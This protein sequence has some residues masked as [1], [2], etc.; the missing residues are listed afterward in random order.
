M[1]WVAKTLQIK[2][3]IFL[4]LSAL[5]DCVEISVFK[6]FTV[7]FMFCLFCILSRIRLKVNKNYEKEPSYFCGLKFYT[8]I[9]K[10]RKKDDI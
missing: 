9:V 2:S 4:I 10:L 3:A 7:V 1:L 5:S 6:M 8:Y